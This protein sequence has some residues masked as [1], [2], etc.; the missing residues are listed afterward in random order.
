MLRD[1]LCGECRKLGVVRVGDEMDHIVPLH[2]G[3]TNRDSNLQ[4]LCSEHH[5]AKTTAEITA[6]RGVGRGCDELGWPRGHGHH[7]HDNKAE[8]DRSREALV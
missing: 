1:P 8:A 3:G 5:R 2:L 4:M 6:L 7:W